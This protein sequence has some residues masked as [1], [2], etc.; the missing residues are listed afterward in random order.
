M[1]I[2]HKRICKDN[3]HV[4]GQSLGADG[5]ISIEGSAATI[6]CRGDVM[7]VDP[8]WAKNFDT[9]PYIVHLSDSIR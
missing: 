5:F 6:Q 9:L 8:S 1:S 4:M 2:E 3:G 7:K